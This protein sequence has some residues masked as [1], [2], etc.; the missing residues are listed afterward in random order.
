MSKKKTVENL[1]SEPLEVLF[2]KLEGL[3]KEMEKEELSLEDSFAMYQQG[4]ALLKCCNQKIDRV[5]KQIMIL[6]G[7]GELHEG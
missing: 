2:T 1:E 6:D 3:I 7:E 4:V 5:E